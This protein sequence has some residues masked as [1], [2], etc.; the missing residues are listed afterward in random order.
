[1]CFNSSAPSVP[2]PAP[3]PP[4]EPPPPPAPAP[5]TAPESLVEPEEVKPVEMGSKR[6]DANNQQAAKG[7]SS[8]RIP[9]G[10]PSQSGGGINVG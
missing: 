1:M 4:N 3:L 5:V 10:T 8:L 7:T 9:L 6:K 2:K